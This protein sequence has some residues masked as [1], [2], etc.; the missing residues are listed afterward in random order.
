MIRDQILA[1][2]HRALETAALPEPEGGV[3]LTPPTQP[4][5]G[6]FTTNVAMRLT[7]VVGLPARE[8]AAKIVVALEAE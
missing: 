5:H 4:G 2:L 7:K 6:D 8:V 1:A 3:E